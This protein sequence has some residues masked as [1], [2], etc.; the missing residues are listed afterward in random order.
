MDHMLK[1]HYSSEDF[2]S[3]KLSTPFKLSDA[4]SIS[5]SKEAAVEIDK[6]AVAS[7]DDCLRI[8]VNAG[9]CAGFFYDFSI[10][11]RDSIEADDIKLHNESVV[12]DSVAASVLRDATVV[13][14][15]S[16]VQSKLSLQF[17]TPHPRVCSCLMSFNW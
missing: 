15:R 2:S 14:Q 12:I 8:N 11:S 5:I 16:I 1:V 17:G 10:E 3:A 9:G 13:F 7:P 6:F 4:P